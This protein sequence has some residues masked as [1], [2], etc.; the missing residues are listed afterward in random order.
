MDEI[1]ESFLRV[2]QDINSLKEDVSITKENLS[3]TKK[4]FV[5]LCDVMT[6]FNEKISLLEKQN[7]DLVSL[8]SSIKNLIKNPKKEISSLQSQKDG[9][10]VSYFSLKFHS[11][12]LNKS[13]STDNTSFSTD[14]TSFSTDNTS[15]STD[16][17]LF[18][19]RKDENQGISIGNGGVQTD[20][21]TN[22]QT[23]KQHIFSS[24]NKNRSNSL[25][26]AEKALDSLDAMKKELRLKFKRLTDQEFLVFSTIYQLN[27]EKGYSDYK[28]I[29]LR[30]GLTESS[31]RDYVRRLINKKIPLEKIKINNKEIQIKIPK[32]LKKIASLSTIIQLISL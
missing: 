26:S 19:I 3:K 15:F 27:E 9:K 14:N 13:F 29:S 32:N 22:K 28:T 4:G 2:K 23:N 16:N 30:L 25:D 7:K 17:T 18:K 10:N 11:F 21:Q 1:K 8:V 5:D 20:R 6:K 12:N 24:Y 31:I